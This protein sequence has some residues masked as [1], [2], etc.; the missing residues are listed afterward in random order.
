MSDSH[1]G[2]ELVSGGLDSQ[3]VAMKLSPGEVVNV[4]KG[5]NSYGSDQ[6]ITLTVVNRPAPVF[7][8]EVASRMSGTAKAGV[9]ASALARPGR[10][11]FR[12]GE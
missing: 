11:G 4:G 12:P 3:L 10:R 8:D 5:A 2:S 9:V 1:S 6:P 7:A